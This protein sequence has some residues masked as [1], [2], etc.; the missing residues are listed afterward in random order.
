MLKSGGTKTVFLTFL[1]RL[2]WFRSRCDF[3]VLQMAESVSKFWQQHAI[4]QVYRNCLVSPHKKCLF[5]VNGLIHK[6]K[7]PHKF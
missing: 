1:Q 5:F 2:S 3:H 6:Q 7:I 4:S